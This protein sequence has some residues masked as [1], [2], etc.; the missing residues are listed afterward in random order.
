M[1][2]RGK[3]AL[4]SVGIGHWGHDKVPKGEERTGGLAGDVHCFPCHS[5]KA[6]KPCLK[7]IVGKEAPCPG[8]DANTPVKQLGYVPVY[9]HDGKPMI[10]VVQ[11]Y[12]FEYLDKLKLH[13]FISW[14][15]E[16]GNGEGVWVK[17]NDLNRPWTSAI[18][19][20]MRPADITEALCKIWR[21]Q[22]WVGFV[23]LWVGEAHAPPPPPP[24]PPPANIVE[25]VHQA[26]DKHRDELRRLMRSQ[27]PLRKSESQTLED[28][29][30][31]PSANG[32][33]KKR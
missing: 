30:P 19:A 21:L 32:R 7:A 9:R 25:A 11:D 16:K 26:E 4:E 22:E 23:R 1:A 17:K 14:G 3:A 12:S 31:E 2:V 10:V 8:C 28:L 6:T 29:L 15:R 27:F 24:P 33:H 20:K 18:P 13:Q 5:S